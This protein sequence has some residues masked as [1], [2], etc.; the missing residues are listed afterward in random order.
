[1]ALDKEI[2]LVPDVASN[3]NNLALENDEGGESTPHNTFGPRRGKGVWRGRPVPEKH[4]KELQAAMMVS[5]KAAT[6]AT[7]AELA[8]QF[9]VSR[10]TVAR[11]LAEAKAN[12][13]V[14]LAREVVAEK[15]LVKALAILNTELDEGSY[16]AAK[17]VIFGTQVLTKG[18]KATVEH[19]LPPSNSILEQVRREI[20]EVEVKEI[21]EGSGEKDE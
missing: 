12:D 8:K 16:E 2:P 3:P 14:Q 20:V 10:P 15:M 21:S 17:D 11:R 19:S 4:V 7:I 13:M 6:N 1:M 5:K 18:T 9:N